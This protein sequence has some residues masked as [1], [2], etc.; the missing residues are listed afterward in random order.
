MSTPDYR[1]C[2]ILFC[3]NEEHI[4]EYTLPYYLRQGIDLVIFDNESTD[5]SMRIVEALQKGR[6]QYGGRILEVLMIKTEGYEWRNILR[7][8]CDYMHQKLSRYEWI[9]LIDA[10]S[11]YHS[12]VEGMTLLEFMDFNKKEHYN[13]LDGTVREFLPTEKDD[14]AIRSPLERLKYFKI[15][16]AGRQHKIFLYH[17]SIDFYTEWGHVCLRDRPRVG[18]V[19]FWYHHYPWVSYEHGLK[20][21][22]KDRKPRYVERKEFPYL[23]PQ[24][25]STLPLE[26]DLIK[27]SRQLHR[28][29][30]EAL[31]I[32]RTR[33][34]WM[35]RFRLLIEACIKFIEA[36]I[37]SFAEPM[38]DRLKKFW[39]IYEYDRPLA[40]ARLLR[41]LK[42]CLQPKIDR[43]P[44][45][46]DSA[47]EILLSEI[48]QQ[49]PFA[50][51]FPQ[52]YHF[53]M[54]DYCNA[55]C[56]FCN[57]N[58]DHHSRKELTLEKFKTLLSHIPIQAARNFHFSG[59]GDPLLCRDLFRI[60]HHINSSYRWVDIRIRTNGLLI[61]KHVEELAR[62][63]IFQLEISVHGATAKTNNAILQ[64]EGRHDL[65]AD[66]ALLN[67]YLEKYKSRMRKVFCSVVSQMNIE[68]IPELIR[69]AAELKAE[70]VNVIFCRYFPHPNGRANGS[71]RANPEDSLFFNQQ[72]YNEVIRAA[73]KLAKVLGISLFHE[74]LFFS[75]YKERPCL[76]PWQNIIIDWEGN[77]YPCTGGEVWFNR[78][79]KSGEYRFGNLLTDHL[80]ECWNSDSY[81]MIRRTCSRFYKEDLVPGCRNCHWTSCFKG[82]D[83]KSGHLLE[84]YEGM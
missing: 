76:E 10:D 65:F 43:R 45:K 54:T 32:S 46:P 13:I 83:V 74:P 30:K 66:V 58:F 26:K 73:K 53:L 27:D 38:G 50:I 36:F 12:P 34:C 14:P 55:D 81:V 25:F 23:H 15:Y 57:Q 64:R 29:R 71:Q 84:P 75:R 42:R 22:F 68:E 51:G 7:F 31:L 1:A 28:F 59:G 70:I 21:I 39:L 18:I 5:S 69:K 80:N 35:M 44:L 40:I 11:F 62:S 52:N 77:I 8:A 41:Y 9:L 49:R 3:Y 24:Y 19:K 6:E 20:K 33:F 79:V 17:R 37:R 60:I 16:D 61:R 72:K 2:G 67:Q 63:R 82:P 48:L 78:K 56:I 4:L 47:H